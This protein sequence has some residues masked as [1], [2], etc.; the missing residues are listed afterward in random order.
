MGKLQVDLLGTSFA[1]QAQEDDEYL[2]KLLGYYK[3]I[4]ES[5]AIPF[6]DGL[7]MLGQP[8]KVAIM[9]GISLCDELYKEKAHTARLEARLVQAGVSPDEGADMPNGL[10]GP[11]ATERIV[12]E[13]LDRLSDV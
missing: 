4:V 12:L 1:I 9:S 11:D 10:T 2:E 5:M 13:M 6:K 8:L 3:Q 7:G